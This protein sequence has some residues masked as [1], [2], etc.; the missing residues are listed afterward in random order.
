MEEGAIIEYQL[1]VVHELMASSRK[2]RIP[3]SIRIKVN[4]SWQAGPSIT[5]SSD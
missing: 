1:T 2:R 4:I 3:V 5:F